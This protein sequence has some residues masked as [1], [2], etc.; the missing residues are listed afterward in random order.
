M[1]RQRIQSHTS[2]LESVR[3]IMAQQ[4]SARRSSL[5]RLSDSSSGVPK[6]LND[7]SSGVPKRLSDSSSGVPK[8]LSD[9]SSGVPKRLNDSSL[10]IVLQWK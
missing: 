4:H 6:R 1:V 3:G 10:W 5:K 7:S 8:R 2:L 9:S